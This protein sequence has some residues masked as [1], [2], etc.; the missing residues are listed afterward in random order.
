MDKLNVPFW[1]QLKLNTSGFT[2]VSIYKETRTHILFW[3]VILLLFLVI[4]AI[5][6]TRQRLHNRVNN[7]VK[8]DMQEEIEEFEQL[9]IET[10][11]ESAVE[12]KLSIETS[13]TNKQ[14]KINN[15]IY[16]LFDEFIT[17]RI[18]ED[19]NFLI[20]IV[21]GQFYKASSLALPD[22]VAPGSKL[23]KRWQSL[24]EEERR[25]QI[26][27]DRDIGSILYKAIPIRTREKTLGVFVI[28]HATTGERQEA[29]EALN[30]II[31]VLIFL[32]AITLLI[33]WFAS[34]RILSP[35]RE[36]AKTVKS[37]DEFDLSQR[38]E[39]KGEGELAELGNT[40]NE[41]MNR[42]E[43]SF[44]IQR[45]FINDAG[46]ELRTPITII[47]GHLELMG[48]DPQ[49]KQE[50][51]NLVID[52][53]DRMNRLV[54]DLILLAKADRPDFLEPE[55]VD[56]ASVTEELFMKIMKLGQRNW[57][58]DSLALGTV[59]LDRQ[60]LTQAIINLANNAVQHT[61][62]SSLIAFGSKIEKK[63]LKFWIRDTGEGI[64]SKEQKRIFERFA[65]VKNSRRRS[66]GSGLGLSIVKAIM[67]AHEGSIS[68]QS[69]LGIGSTF[70]LIFPLKFNKKTNE[71]NFNR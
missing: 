40:F 13:I 59:T 39:I 26:V 56:I 31:E 49:E 62:S 42:I 52:E 43:T 11:L 60:R 10:L 21:D 58:L 30:V 20:A 32:L 68:L 64:D 55:L 54:E 25:E 34:G 53:L 1:N 33:A 71:A 66:E 12:P 24:N 45:D 9:L 65:R 63:C 67:E 2:K 48:D 29:L 6:I 14:Q 8:A 17:N 38:I 57:Y 41:M 22:V 7:R 50:T 27:A 18:T 44:D 46:H 37:I 23:M 4:T 15:K 16:K 69:H 28:A 19:D 47:R 70:T 36:L 51:V 5:P 3:Y 35:L 61:T